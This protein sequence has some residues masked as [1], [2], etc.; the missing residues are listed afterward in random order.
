[1][2]IVEKFAMLS[3]CFTLQSCYGHF[4]HASGQDTHNL[5]R[6]PA[7]YVGLVTYRIAYI[8]FCL[9]NSRSGKALFYE[10]S[11]IPEIDTDFVQFG[12]ADWFWERHLNSY[13][14][15]VEPARHMNKDQIIV[16]HS[17]A[18]HIQ[19]IRDLF[20]KR[21]AELLDSPKCECRKG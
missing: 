15:Q 3:H 9:E 19:H 12:S 11:R 1:M 8:A 5:G 20:F 14:L 13:V 18:Q 7:R 16:E 2:A 10:L 4:L 17:E 6:L 21:L